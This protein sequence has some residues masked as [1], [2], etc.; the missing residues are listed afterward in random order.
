M[1]N[2]LMVEDVMKETGMGPLARLLAW[3]RMEV[4]SPRAW[5]AVPSSR[6]DLTG[7]RESA[8]SEMLHLGKLR[9]VG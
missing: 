3:R 7:S 2:A 8:R 1:L 9:S 5:N 4:R 6:S